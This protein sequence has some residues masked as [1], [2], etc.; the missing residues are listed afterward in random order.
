[1][2]IR[3]LLGSNKKNIIKYIQKY[4]VNNFKYLHNKTKLIKIKK[5]NIREI[6]HVEKTK[7]DVNVIEKQAITIRK[8]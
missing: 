1:M 4:S 7:A 2:S 8:S 5:I 3:R 6:T